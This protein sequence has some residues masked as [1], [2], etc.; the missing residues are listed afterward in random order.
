M[1]SL[2]RGDLG[3]RRGEQGGRKRPRPTA[4]LRVRNNQTLQPQLASEVMSPLFLCQR[5]AVGISCTL[6]HPSVSYN[7]ELSSPSLPIHL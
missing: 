7:R 6:Q 5:R 4:G 2:I 1:W 3:A